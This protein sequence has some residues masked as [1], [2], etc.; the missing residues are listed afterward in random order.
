MYLNTFS[1]MEIIYHKITFLILWVGMFIIRYPHEKRQKKNNIIIS[2][3]GKKEVIL[4]IGVFIGMMLLP[5]IYIF[6]PFLNITNYEPIQFLLIVGLLLMP[7]TFW[8]FYRS[9][10]DLGKN[11]SPTLEVIEGHKIVDKGVYKFIRHPMYTACWLWVICQAFLLPNYIS[12]LSGLLG[13]GLLYFL[14]VKQEEVM[15]Q[16][17]FGKEYDQYMLKTKRLIPFL[18]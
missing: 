13:F 4:L 1:T 15:M 18:F 17:Q 7:F 6:T 11:W 14:R 8:L 16:K 12:G 2:K 9:H 3:K 5:M 10:K